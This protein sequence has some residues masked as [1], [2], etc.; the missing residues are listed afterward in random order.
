MNTSS[1]LVKS[2][3][4]CPNCPSSDAY[5]TYDDGHGYCFSCNTYTKEDGLEI[6][7]K[8]DKAAEF[9][10]PFKSMPKPPVEYDPYAGMKETLRPIRGVSTDTMR[11]YRVSVLTDSSDT[12]KYMVYP[13]GKQ[14]KKYRDLVN[15]DFRSTGLIS[16]AGLF[17]EDIFT[18]GMAREVLITE[19]ELDALSAYQMLGGTIPCV[20]VRNAATAAKDCA[21]S[22]KYLNGFDRIILC[23]DNDEPGRNAAQQIARLF[24]INKV[25]YVPVADGLKDANDYLVANRIAEFAK[26]VQNADRFRPKNIISSNAQV[27]KALNDDQSSATVASYPFPTLNDLTKGIRLNEV[28]LF[29]AQEK[30]GKTEVMRAIEHHLVKTTDYNLGIIH[31]EEKERRAICGL[32]G[33]EVE[34]PV[35]LP[36]GGFSNDDIAKVYAKLTKRDDRVHFYSHFGSDDPDEI[37][38]IIRYMVTVCDCKFVFLDHITMLVTGFEDEDERKKLDY[39][40]T[41]LA[42]MTRELQFTLFLVSHVN[43]NGQ[44]RGSRNIAKVADLII[45]LSRNI[46]ADD[47]DERNTTKLLVRGNRFAGT[48]GPAGHLYFDPKTYVL[49]EM[50]ADEIKLSKLEQE[51]AKANA[52]F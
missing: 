45:H 37:L 46:E 27:L 28:N 47:Q 3:L 26:A 21:K 6:T 40:S 18:A 5:A 44:T 36:D 39:I 1:K 43:D 11:K 17:G 20:S 19:G 7:I 14:A 29:L 24:D 8:D 30:I 51:N 10:D 33:Y 25:L 50:T 13:Y 4:P 16:E 12:P 42:M 22:I 2:G 9:M 49:K 41:R 48:T 32:V 23:L 38:R 52:K 15:K 31:L 34:A 35:H